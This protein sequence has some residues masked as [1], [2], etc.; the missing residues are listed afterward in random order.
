MSTHSHHDEK[1]ILSAGVSR[2]NFLALLASSGTAAA[3]ATYMPNAVHA[4]STSPLVSGTTASNKLTPKDALQ[5]LLDGNKR[6][7]TSKAEHP[8]QTADRRVE[9]ASGQHPIAIILS[10][11]D[12]RVPPE[13]LFDQGLGDLFVMRTAGNV[14]DDAVLGSIEY[15]VAE[16][17]IPL[18]V[19]LGHERC[20]AVKATVEGH[21]VPGHIA[22]LVKAIKPAFD[23]VKAEAGDVVDNTVRANALMVADQ[24]AAAEPILSEAVKAGKL[25]I[26]AARYDLDAGEVEVLTK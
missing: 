19:V 23:K 1:P 25:M 15:G 14:L 18:L 7:V 13:I 5:V 3:L 22:Y 4:A 20:G 9:V 16:L 8:D 21:E 2:R 6:Y 11:S 12:S 24:L 10:C 17:E 26:V